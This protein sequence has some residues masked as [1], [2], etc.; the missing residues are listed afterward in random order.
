MISQKSQDRIRKINEAVDISQTKT[1]L[2]VVN[3]AMKRSASMYKLNE[4]RRY[5]ISFRNVN[6]VQNTSK[7]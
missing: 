6:D 2:G 3:S 7:T 1:A 5:D 4:V